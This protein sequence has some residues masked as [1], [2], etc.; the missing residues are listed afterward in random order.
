MET[1]KILEA[2][3]DV[4]SDTANIIKQMEQRFNLVAEKLEEH[5]NEL[6]KHEQKW[7]TYERVTREKNILI[8]GLPENEKNRRDLELICL[9]LLTNVLKIDISITEIDN[10]YRVGSN[11][12]EKVR[13]VLI[14]FIA[15]RKVI[16]IL[17]NRKNLKGSNIVISE[18][19][20]KKV[21]EDRKELI[22]V[23]K[24]MRK[25]GKHAIIKYNEL[26]VEGNKMD[27]IEAKKMIKEKGDK[28]R[29]LSEENEEETTNTK[30]ESS[31]SKSKTE[32]PD[33]KRPK[34]R[35]NIVNNYTSGPSNSGAKPIFE[36]MQRSR[37]NS[38]DDRPIKGN[39]T[40][41]M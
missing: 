33:A 29:I 34:Q 31:K 32:N 2:I 17:S 28:K 5:K 30:E 7:E 1:K 23:M 8:F 14:K 36:Y 19:F 4:K 39:T 13:P 12:G 26:Y 20:P 22:P 15:R 21:Q 18:D 6:S 27:K 9:E 10:M 38:Y 16:E 3:Q 24:E 35:Q 40:R 37:A 41:P 25:E 11:R